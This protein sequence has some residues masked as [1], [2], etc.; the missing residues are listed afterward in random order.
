[1]E[2]RPIIRIWDCGKGI[3][4]VDIDELKIKKKKAYTLMENLCKIYKKSEDK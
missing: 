1:M 3:Y 4:Q 2:E